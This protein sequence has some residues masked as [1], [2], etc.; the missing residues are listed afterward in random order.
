MNEQIFNLGVNNSRE[1]MNF[2]GIHWTSSYWNHINRNI[3]YLKFKEQEFILK[4]FY[5]LF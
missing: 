4:I 2:D 1:F 5:I 3:G